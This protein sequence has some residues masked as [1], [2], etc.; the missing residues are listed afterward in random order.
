MKKNFKRYAMA[1]IWCL[2]F[3]SCETLFS[4]K[5]KTS[6]EVVTDPPVAKVYINGIFKG[7]APCTVENIQ[8]GEYLISASLDAFYEERKTIAVG[9][10][11][12]ARVSIRLEPITALLLLHSEPP[13]ADVEINGNY[14]GK[15]PLFLQ[16]VMFG[17]KEINFSKPGYLSKKIE[18]ILTDR[19]P[20]K[21]A[22]TLI[23]NYGTLAVDSIPQGAQ[24]I[25]DGSLMGS[26]PASFEKVATGE[27]TIE[28]KLEGAARWERSI[29]LT[30]GGNVNIAAQLVMLPAKLKVSSVPTGARIIVNGQI[31]ETSS[32]DQIEVKSGTVEV[33]ADLKGYDACYKTIQLKPGEDASIELKLEKSSGTLLVATEPPGVNIFLDGEL[34]GSTGELGDKPVSE[35]IRIEAVSQGEHKLLLTRSGYYDKA[36]NFKI[37]PK[38]TLTFS[39]KLAPRPVA[40]I[41]NTIVRIGEG[42]AYSTYR[43]VLKEKYPNGDI[44]MEINPGIYKI[45]PFHDILSVEP[46]TNRFE[47][48]R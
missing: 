23:G 10:G 24:I 4:A 42:G 21:I 47:P 16:N 15:T 30:A 44:K 36:L 2:I 20:K 14:V 48:G 35:Q 32:L 27:H 1:A 45:F 34:C 5:T 43:G 38:E 40:F 37:E 11:E 39:E 25:M 9:V 7:K 46:I 41:P 33:G 28:L 18:I 12:I 8:P 3:A 19:T 13:D 31:A 26:T 17:K 22:T 6:I 29:S